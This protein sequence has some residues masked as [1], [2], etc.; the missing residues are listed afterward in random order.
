MK[1]LIRKILREQEEEIITLPPFSFFAYDWNEVLEYADGR[2]FRINGN[3]NLSFSN[4]TT[5]G[6]LVEVDGDLDLA[7]CYELQSLGK[8]ESVGG[9]LN[10]FR[11]VNLQSLGELR[12]VGGYLNLW[13]CEN[14]ESLGELRNVVSWFNLL[15]CMNLKSLDKLE[16]V[17]GDLNLYDCQNLQ[18]LGELRSV[19][20][21]LDL[22]GTLIVNIMDYWDI[23]TKVRLKGSMKY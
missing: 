19:G 16:S 9:N 7:H 12:S 22:R 14:L 13:G 18:S 17:D 15:D 3:I 10:L 6:G 21:G 20:G 1:Q 4:I 23:I 2:L 11:C 8:L 5:L